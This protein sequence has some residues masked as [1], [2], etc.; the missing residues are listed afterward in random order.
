MSPPAAPPQIRTGGSTSAESTSQ[1]QLRIRAAHRLLDI[2]DI[3]MSPSRVSRLVRQFD[4][5]I[6]RNGWTFFE[7]FANTCQLTVEQRR[8]AGTDPELAYFLRYA[9]RTGEDAVWNVQNPSK[10]PRGY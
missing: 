6:Q 4:A 8:R 10:P 7:F 2:L 3:D 9:D 5:R 1:T